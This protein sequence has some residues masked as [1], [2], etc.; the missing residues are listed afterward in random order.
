MN[1]LTSQLI[2][3]GLLRKPLR[4]IF[5]VLTVVGAIASFASTELVMKDLMDRTVSYWRTYDYDLLVQGPE[6]HQLQS[7]VA[8][9]RGVTR[10]EKNLMLP[11][12]VGLN[13]VD[14]ALVDDDSRLLPISLA[15]GRSPTDEYEIVLAQEM[16]TQNELVV[17]D[18]LSLAA[19]DNMDNVVTFIVSGIEK[20]A[21]SLVTEKGAERIHPRFRDYSA[22]IIKIDG[23]VSA[24]TIETQLRQLPEVLRVRNNDQFMYYDGSLSVAEAVVYVTRVLLLAVGVVSLYTLLHLGQQERYYEL[25]VLRA[26]GFSLRKITTT[27]LLEG[28]FILAAG[29]ILALTLVVLLAFV[30]DLGAW[31]MIIGRYLP[32]SLIVFLLGLLAV[33]WTAWRAASR[34]ITMLFK[35]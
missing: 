29:I 19:I 20:G 34:P 15:D 12:I 22:L 31:N 17:G 21:T 10:V 1:A 28:L 33:A 27:L 25:G 3:W 4:T 11:V 16:A 13:E 7:E 24:S 14:I 18:E 23:S 26:L 6:V 35:A 5:L 2:R 30:F 32:G 8:G 9:F